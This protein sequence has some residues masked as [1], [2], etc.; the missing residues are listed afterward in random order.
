MVDRNRA[1]VDISQ[2]ES[3][4]LN[5]ENKEI[6]RPIRDMQRQLSD[7]KS[8]LLQVDK[9]T[10]KYKE[11]LDKN[12]A[13]GRRLQ[14]EL[15]KR[16]QNKDMRAFLGLLYRIHALEVENME[17]KEMND[18]TEPLLH[19]KDLEAEALRLQIQL[20]DR[21]VE[22]HNELIREASHSPIPVPK[23]WLHVPQRDRDPAK[24]VDPYAIA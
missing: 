14:V 21:M 24:G 22:E 12:I 5:E 17:L 3:R 16:V 19:N 20:R 23:G 2:W 11:E 18:M 15:P 10:S 8:D 6:P 7:V 1:Q 4:N 9:A 13:V